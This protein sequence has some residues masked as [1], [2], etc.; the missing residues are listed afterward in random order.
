MSIELIVYFF[1][2]NRVQQYTVPFLLLYFQDSRDNTER[3]V[4]Y[5]SD[6]YHVVRAHLLIHAARFA[7][8]PNRHDHTNTD[9]SVYLQYPY[10]GLE[11]ITHMFKHTSFSYY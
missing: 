7:I 4:S 9:Q 8:N 10:L 5:E 2:G 3:D 11:A 6:R 1:A